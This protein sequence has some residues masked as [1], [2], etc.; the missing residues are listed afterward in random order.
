MLSVVLLFN[1]CA[2]VLGTGL[3]LAIVHELVSLMGSRIHVES[4]QGVGSC[5]W[6]ELDVHAH[7]IHVQPSH[8]AID[9]DGQWTATDTVQTQSEHGTPT[10]AASHV[11]AAVV[12]LHTNSVLPS[13]STPSQAALTS[14]S[15][16]SLSTTSSPSHPPSYTP[17]TP[18]HVHVTTPPTS[19]YTLLTSP[20][21]ATSMPASSSSSCS[22]TSSLPSSPPTSSMSS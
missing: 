5:F 15:L 13:T 21:A 8:F 7:H 12:V 11:D 22:P 16:S 18:L 1:I 14:L 2:L 3:G 6:F 17:S 9:M 19:H 4:V 10:S 20:D